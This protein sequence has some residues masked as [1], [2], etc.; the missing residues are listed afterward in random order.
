MG[1]RLYNELEKN[2]WRHEVWNRARALSILEGGYVLTLAGKHFKDR[3]IAARYGFPKKKTIGIDLDKGI[4]RHN[5]SLGRTVLNIST[6]Q[7]LRCWDKPVSAINLD[8]CSNLSSGVVTDMVYLLCNRSFDNSCVILNVAVGRERKSTF[9]LYKQSDYFLGSQDNRALSALFMALV[10]T[11][12]LDEAI[13]VLKSRSL[14]ISSGRYRARKQPMDWI[15]FNRWGIKY[16]SSP[17]MEAF[18]KKLY[19][20][21]KWMLKVK[22][23]VAAKMAWHTRNNPS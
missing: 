17:C 10:S 2:E 12:G 18:K 14:A 7:A 22:R 15:V 5:A 16:K 13:R 9:E 6:T 23:H 4:C 3:K 8:Y 21:N 20:H 19:K 11:I 1:Q